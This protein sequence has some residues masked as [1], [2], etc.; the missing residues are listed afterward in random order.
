MGSPIGP[1]AADIVMQRVL[2]IASEN[3]PLR[4]GFIKKYVDNLLVSIHENDVDLVVDHFNSVHPKIQFSM[5]MEVNGVLPYLDMEIHRGE[6]NSLSTTWY[7]KPSSSLRMLNY[8]SGHSLHTIIN[9]GRGFIKRVRALTTKSGENTNDNIAR[10]LRKND[11]PNRVIQRL[12]REEG[13]QNSTTTD[14]LYFNTISYVRGISEKLGKKIT[15]KTGK[16]VAFQPVTKVRKFFSRIKDPIPKD[17]K[18]DVV[19]EIPC[20]GCEKSYIGTTGQ[21]LK[22]RLQQ[23]KNDTKLPIRNPN[24]SSLCT[25]VTET[26]HRFKFEETKILDTHR[27]YGKRL[28]LEMIHIKTN[29]DKVVNKRSDVDGLSAIYAG[30]LQG[31][32]S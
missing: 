14:Q 6:N 10:I 25:H 32:H 27:N 12:L 13:Q 16:K 26:G 1:I 8:R 23:H 11:F 2:N 7:A 4:I 30:L 24:V 28:L 22:K 29:M 5:E 3:S 20:G 9:V 19:Y 18:C 21:Q 15:E 17:N 31:S